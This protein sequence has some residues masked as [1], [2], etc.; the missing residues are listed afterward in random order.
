[1]LLVVEIYSIS[2]KE[3]LLRLLLIHLFCFQ[4][5]LHLFTKPEKMTGDDKW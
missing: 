3:S 1:M 4:D 5:C 2:F